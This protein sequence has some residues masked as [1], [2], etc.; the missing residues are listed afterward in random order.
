MWILTPF[1]FTQ[2]V[3]MECLPLPPQTRVMFN[4]EAKLGSDGV[5]RCV[6]I[7]PFRACGV[8]PIAAS[9]ILG[10]NVFELAFAGVVE[11]EVEVREGEKEIVAAFARK[12]GES[13][14]DLLP[15]LLKD[16]FEQDGAERTAVEVSVLLEE[17]DKATFEIHDGRIFELKKRD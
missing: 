9:E 2:L 8:A 14:K 10:R 1:Q 16:L 3:V 11:E 4:V 7:N 6:E 5:L 17:K 12:E 15:P 13:A